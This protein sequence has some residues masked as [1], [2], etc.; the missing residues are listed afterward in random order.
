M[1]NNLDKDIPENF[2]DIFSQGIKPEQRENIKE[3]LQQN[4]ES[5]KLLWEIKDIWQ[6]SATTRHEKDYDENIA[7][8]SLKQNLKINKPVR[9]LEWL[10]YAAIAIV[11]SIIAPLVY[12]YFSQSAQ[13]IEVTYQ[14]VFV[15]YGSTSKIALPD[16]SY[17]WLNAGSYLKYSSA[18]NVNNRVVEL[19]GEAFFE[20]HKNKELAFIVQTPGIEVKAIGTKFNV[21]SY[22]EEKTIFTTVVEGKIQVINQIVSGKSAKEVFLTTNQTASFLKEYT[23]PPL[24]EP[25]VIKSQKQPEAGHDKIPTR[26]LGINSSVNTNIFV[27][28]RKGEL[29]IE[30]EKLGSLAIK[31]ERRYNVKIQFLDESVKDY[32]FSGIL[33]DETF[34][35]V[36]DVIRFTSPIRFSID[37]NLVSLKEDK[38]LKNRL[39]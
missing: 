31:L 26:I 14:E 2:A 35:Q 9:K 22:P 32:V 1:E 16:G 33:K 4:N 38:S 23:N 36:M 24:V 15:P 3:W 13:Q 27:S 25:Q 39:N 17:V 6:A 34:E 18:F 20:V 7:W 11:F 5:P 21:K 10:K 30:R 37:G 28:W 12:Y 8:D 19:K 29:I